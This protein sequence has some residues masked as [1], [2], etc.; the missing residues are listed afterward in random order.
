MPAPQFPPVIPVLPGGGRAR[1]IR[2]R[3][4]ALAAVRNTFPS[5]IPDST[6]GLRLG[7]YADA[8]GTGCGGCNQVV[9]VAPT[10][11]L[12]ICVYACGTIGTYPCNALITVTN[13]TTNAVIGQI[14]A[15]ASGCVTI[16]YAMS[17]TAPDTGCV[18]IAVNPENSAYSSFSGQYTITCVSATISIGLKP[19]N[20]AAL[21][22]G[23]VPINP[24]LTLTDANGS[25]P[26]DL[27]AWQPYSGGPVYYNWFA[28]YLSPDVSPASEWNAN[29]SFTNAV[30]SAPITIQYTGSCGY[31][32]DGN[33]VFNLRRNWILWNATA[34]TPLYYYYQYPP[35]AGG[36]CIA[37]GLYA[38]A[39]QYIWNYCQ[40]SNGFR[41]G[42]G[43][44]G[45]FSSAAFGL[46]PCSPFAVSGT[47]LHNPAAPS[48]YPPDPVGG[49]VAIS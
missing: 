47:L 41:Y 3:G 49:S 22:C 16:P 2:Q 11:N 26:F 37:A 30:V 34:G 48:Y 45:D 46:T 33:P 12:K 13:C 15:G 28:C 4:D 10:C 14:S 1:S 24:N 18:N 43:N 40:N 32:A 27:C 35:G 39:N 23:G 36:P 38:C 20:A 29:C 7:G 9:T 31:D 6:F 42:G 44:V 17:Q 25:H 21:C 8:S 19:A 5:I